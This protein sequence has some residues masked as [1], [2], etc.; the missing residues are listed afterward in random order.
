M[1]A[2]KGLCFISE[3]QQLYEALSILDTGQQ[4]ESRARQMSQDSREPKPSNLQLIYLSLPS[5]NIHACL[6]ALCFFLPISLELQ[7]LCQVKKRSTVV[8][9]HVCLRPCF[10]TWIFALFAVKCISLTVCAL[11]FCM[12]HLSWNAFP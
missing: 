12:Q 7:Y 2:K 5:C 3:H 9:T 8:V 1:E 6:L 11:V 10:V 4:G